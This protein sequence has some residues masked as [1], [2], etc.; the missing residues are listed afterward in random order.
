MRT[1][2]KYPLEIVAHEQVVVMPEYSRVLAFQMQGDV[3]TFW[4]DVNT[5][6]VPVQRR[7]VIIGTG[8]EIPTNYSYI[9]TTQEP[10]YVW[11]LYEAL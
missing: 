4:A 11:H 5:N 6:M 9:G 3:P 7:F 10:P 2:H 8:G 1:I